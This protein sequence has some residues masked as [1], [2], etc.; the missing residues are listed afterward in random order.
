MS[1]MW[2]NLTS[3]THLYVWRDRYL[4][5]QTEPTQTWPTHTS[6][7]T[8]SYVWNDSRICMTWLRSTSAATIVLVKS[9]VVVRQSKSGGNY[10]T[11]WSVLQIHM[12]HDSW[13]FD[14]FMTHLNESFP[15]PSLIDMRMTLFFAKE[16]LI[17][18]LFCKKWPMKMGRVYDTLEWVI[19]FSLRH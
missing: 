4:W 2:I 10:T 8:P 9:V 18:G 7:M 3:A 17:T 15:F 19:S 5:P 6:D 14:M 1:L 13:I 11:F 12:W 16:P